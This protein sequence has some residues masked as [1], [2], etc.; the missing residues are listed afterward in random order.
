MRSLF[1]TAAVLA[2]A[3]CKPGPHAGGHGWPV[4]GGGW[5]QPRVPTWVDRAGNIHTPYTTISPPPGGYGPRG[6]PPSFWGLNNPYRPN[7]DP[8]GGD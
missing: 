4:H 8:G 7:T 5:G 1:L 6:R 2:L 3:A